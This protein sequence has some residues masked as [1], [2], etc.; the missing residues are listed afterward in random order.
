MGLKDAYLKIED[1]WFDFLDYLDDKGIPVY[2][3]IDPLEKNGIPSFPVFLIFFLLLGIFLFSALTGQG[4]LGGM[5]NGG[6]LFGGLNGGGLFGG[7]G[8]VNFNAEVVNSLNHSIPSTLSI[9][10]L[11]F[12]SIKNETSINGFFNLS[13]KK[14]D[15]YLTINSQNCSPI[16]NDYLDLT[17]GQKEFNKQYKL[18]CRGVS[19]SSGQSFCFEPLISGKIT[20]TRYKDGTAIGTQ[21]CDVTDCVVNL[22]RDDN[23]TYVFS[24]DEYSSYGYTYSDLMEYANSINNCISMG[25]KEDPNKEYASAVFKIIDYEGEKVVGAPVQM[26]SPSDTSYVI[27]EQVS[28]DNG[29]VEFKH[30]EVGEKFKIKIIGTNDTLPYLSDKVYTIPHGG[31]RETL[32]MTRTTTSEIK[33]LEQ[34]DYGSPINLTGALITIYDETGKQVTSKS[35]NNKGK[36]LFGLIK[37]KEYSFSIYKT[38]VGY[39]TGYTIKGGENKTVTVISQAKKTTGDIHLKVLLAGQNLPN[40]QAHLKDSEGVETGIVAPPTNN[41]GETTFSTVPEGSYCVTIS[42]NI[43]NESKC[44][45]VEVKANKTVNLKINLEKNIFTYLFNIRNASGSNLEGAEVRVLAQNGSLVGKSTTGTDGIAKINLEEGL[46]PHI[47]VRYEKDGKT[48]LTDETLAEVT[49]NKNVTIIIT[50]TSLQAKIIGIIDQAKGWNYVNLTNETI[51]SD[52]NA[53]KVVVNIGL[54]DYNNKKWDKVNFEITSKDGIAEFGKG[55]SDDLQGFTPTEEAGL[56]STRN[57]SISNYDMAKSIN[58]KIPIVIKTAALKAA[59]TDG[60]GI[61]DVEVMLKATWIQGNDTFS[62]PENNS[63]E[64]LDFNATYN[65]NSVVIGSSNV[66][67]QTG[68]EKNGHAIGPDDYNNLE[69]KVGD[70]FNMSFIIE[71][72]GDA[73]FNG[74]IKIWDDYNNINISSMNATMN[75]TSLYDDLSFNRTNQEVSISFKNNELNASSHAVLSI[76]SKVVGQPVIEMEAELNGNTVPLYSLD[77]EGGKEASIIIDKPSGTAYDL[78]NNITFHVETTDG[79]IIP[80]NNYAYNTKIS[81]LEGGNEIDVTK[82]NPLTTINEENNSITVSFTKDYHLKGGSVFEIDTEGSLIKGEINKTTNVM[83]CIVSPITQKV[84]FFANATS[85]CTINLL[86]NEDNQLTYF[87]NPYAT[88]EEGNDYNVEVKNVCNADVKIT[89]AVYDP[90]R[91]GGDYKQISYPTYSDTYAS[92]DSGQEGAVTPTTFTMPINVTVEATKGSLTKEMT[93]QF[94]LLERTSNP[95]QGGFAGDSYAPFKIANFYSPICTED[96]Y[97]TVQQLARYL[98]GRMHS[99]PKSTS[100]EVHNVNLL[101]D[102]INT[103]GGLSLIELTNTFKQVMGE[104]NVSL[105]DK[106]PD[107]S[108]IENGKLYILTSALGGQPTIRGQ[109]NIIYLDKAN[110]ATKKY[111]VIS[112]IKEDESKYDP[113]VRDYAYGAQLSFPYYNI[114]QGISNKQKIQFITQGVNF[115]DVKDNIEEIFNVSYKLTETPVVTEGTDANTNKIYLA[116]CPTTDDISFN[117]ICGKMNVY[118]NGDYE[119]A[120]LFKEKGAHH[121]IYFLGRTLQDLKTLI[122]SYS[123]AVEKVNYDKVDAGDGTGDLEIHIGKVCLDKDYKLNDTWNPDSGEA[124]N[125][126]TFSSVYLTPTRSLLTL[127]EL[128]SGVEQIDVQQG[129]T[130][131]YCAD[132]KLD[133]NYLAKGA[134]NDNGTVAKALKEYYSNERGVSEDKIQLLNVPVYQNKHDKRY[135]ADAVIVSKADL[136]KATNKVLKEDILA[137]INDEGSTVFGVPDYYIAKLGNMTYFIINSPE[138]MT[139]LVND[140]G[141]IK[142]TGTELSKKIGY[143]IKAGSGWDGKTVAVEINDNQEPC[144]VK[145]T[146]EMFGIKDYDTAKQQTTDYDDGEL[147]VLNGVD[148]SGKFLIKINSSSENKLISEKKSNTTESEGTPVTDL[149]EIRKGAAPAAEEDYHYTG[150]ENYADSSSD[151]FYS[152]SDYGEGIDGDGGILV[153]YAPSTGCCGWVS[154]HEVTYPTIVSGENLCKEVVKGNH[155]EVADDTSGSVGGETFKDC[156]SYWIKGI[157]F[158]AYCGTKAEDYYSSYLYCN[159]SYPYCA[160]QVN[161]GNPIC[162]PAGYE[163]WNSTMK[164]CEKGKA[165]EPNRGVQIAPGT[166]SGGYQQGILASSDDVIC[167]SWK[168]TGGIH[169]VNW[170]C[171]TDHQVCIKWKTSPSD[172]AICCPKGY[173]NYFSKDKVCCPTDM[174]YDETTGYCEYQN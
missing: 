68:L 1:K 95:K 103:G 130:H 100:E 111:F 91:T 92:Y 173:V 76:Q 33:V 118:A 108:Q 99:M 174:T 137:A 60:D 162:C 117:D 61:K 26:V 24:S 113:L 102:D 50:E 167:G 90:S 71:N 127:D 169:T 6:G 112:Q 161:T 159:N 157:N 128:R 89:S 107:D 37:D 86:I 27:K 9:Y 135:V 57:F 105:V 163:K 84:N 93:W 147:T 73:P 34:K 122:N 96:N 17:S 72:Q 87:T 131:V 49:G 32:K 151:N 16:T 110:T 143:A 125:G 65:K 144:N 146:L 58:V 171:G 14:G 115:S 119:S 45:N 170:L 97:C 53:Y 164:W 114:T 47:S 168:D 21:K 142:M 40:A 22:V 153:G 141:F 121:G 38:G 148:G 11:D 155:P 140:K 165:N 88:C 43:G 85:N 56:L 134:G 36:A 19:L 7:R 69:T 120:M 150:E 136:D 67:I 44:Y 152:L 59:D 51:A 15:Y 79:K 70:L 10:D 139:T 66:V 145:K 48:Y 154:W 30:R 124:C 23:S 55:D 156:C 78:T 28:D 46:V 80:V 94:D 12:N 126:H 74:T 52:S 81:R 18:D 172:T 35:T 64:K 106:I 138:N 41:E 5:F 82:T 31:L 8:Q 77:V 63:Y 25:V 39:F 42:R 104:Q 109:G 98:M 160:Q 129:I 62:Y 133:C 158:T 166:P 20:L 83:N 29:R 3:L 123:L 149:C 2:T 75:G 4:P 54:P 13:L 116:V 132:D 101:I